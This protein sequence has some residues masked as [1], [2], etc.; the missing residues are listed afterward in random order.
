MHLENILIT[1]FLPF[2]GRAINCSQ[3]VARATAQKLNCPHL[4]LPVSFDR[5]FPMFKN[6]VEKNGPFD[7][8]I[9]LGEAGTRQKI[10]IER[11]ALNWRESKN[12]DEDGHLPTIGSIQGESPIAILNPQIRPDHFAD[13]FNSGRVEFS[14]SAGTFVCN[15]LYFQSLHFFKNSRTQ[16]HFIHLPY[17]ESI[18]FEDQ[19]DIIRDLIKAVQIP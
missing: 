5:S 13:T 8:I 19:I 1:G 12:A 10:G 16:I 15:D 6:Y 11:L 2:G 17:F 9:Q 7:F 4:I 14:F 18:P 3:E